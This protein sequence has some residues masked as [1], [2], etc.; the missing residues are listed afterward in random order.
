[1]AVGLHANVG[2]MHATMAIFNAFCDRVPILMFGATGP[3]DATRRRPWIDWIH[4]AQ[5]QGALIRPY[6]K[7]DDQPHSAQAAV[8]SVIHAFVAAKS[9]PCAPT[10]VCLDLSLQEDP[11]DPK[12]IT[13]PDTNRY[14]N[15]TEKPGPSMED[16]LKL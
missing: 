1:M 11:I 5:D 15:A 6:I 3:L 8:E 14:L 9:K 4:T 10:Y 2:L 12:T 16:I 13:F 7:F